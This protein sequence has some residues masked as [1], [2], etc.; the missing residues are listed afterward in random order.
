MRECPKSFIQ[1]FLRTN[2]CEPNNAKVK[3]YL[4]LR[5]RSNA[6]SWIEPDVYSK[7]DHLDHKGLMLVES[8]DAVKYD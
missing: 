1:F 2:N 6:I 3:A 4:D 8:S 7:V 5:G